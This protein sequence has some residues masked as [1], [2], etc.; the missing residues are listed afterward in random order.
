MI[1]NNRH[2]PHP[3]LGIGDDING[4]GQVS[5]KVSSDSEYIVLENTF[6]LE[7]EDL[8]K[9]IEQKKAS[10]SMHL[11]CRGTFY[12]A[13]YTSYKPLC[14]EIKLKASDL[15]G[16]VELNYLVCAEIDIAKYQNKASNDDYENFQFDINRGDILAYLG[17]G[18]FYANKTF[19]ET[20]S[21]SSFMNI[22]TDGR[23][24]HPYYL[25]YG[26]EKITIYLS[27]EDYELYQEIKLKKIAPILH[28]SLVLPALVQV[29]ILMDGEE[30]EEYRNSAWFGILTEITEK[31]GED[32]PL[33]KAQKI[34]ELPLKRSFDSMK[35]LQL[36]Y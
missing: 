1:Y 26:D 5:L 3:V 27:Q 11:E 20:T 35:E 4:K 36:I 8:S 32:E 9:L 25:D 30:S 14:D 7:N 15:N 18:K 33:I 13:N 6:L 28:S 31:L 22:N 34:L 29:L 23:S 16:E 24:N 17:K 19:Q 2:Y 21:I 10:F 12:R